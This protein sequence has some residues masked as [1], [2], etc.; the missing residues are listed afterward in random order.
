MIDVLT[1]AHR[2]WP[3]LPVYS[4]G[5]TPMPRSLSFVDYVRYP[6]VSQARIQY[7]RSLIWLS[8]SK[9]EGFGL[10]LLEAMACGAVV[11]TAS[12]YGSQDIVRDR[13]NGVFA[14]PPECNRFLDQ[15]Q[16]L[17][18]DRELRDALAR[19]G[20]ETIHHFSWE[21]AAT[22]MELVLERLCGR[23]IADA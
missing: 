1:Q 9:S 20:L 17:L 12:N 13:I 5:M 8:T 14:Q 10:P 15:I 7:N 22:E 21:R 18:E 2:K 16:M 4:F 23:G 19:K 6:S 3:T 11:V